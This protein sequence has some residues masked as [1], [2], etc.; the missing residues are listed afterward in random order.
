M[1]CRTV[2]IKGPYKHFDSRAQG[3]SGEGKQ[4]GTAEFELRDGGI[5]RGPKNQRMIALVFTGHEFGEGGDVILQQLE[6]HHA[7]ASFFLTGDF[8]RNLEFKKIGDCSKRPVS[9]I[10]LPTL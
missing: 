8:L 6:R 10:Q 9:E 4:T 3:E 1:S 5:L 2:S 7:Q